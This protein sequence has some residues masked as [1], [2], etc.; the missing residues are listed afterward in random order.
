[1]VGHSGQT[2]HILMVTVPFVWNLA[3]FSVIVQL[4]QIM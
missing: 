4:V 1:M 2:D 3:C